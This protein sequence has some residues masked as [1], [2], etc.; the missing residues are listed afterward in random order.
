MMGDAESFALPP[1]IPR[2]ST[3]PDYGESSFQLKGYSMTTISKFTFGVLLAV[4]AGSFSIAA[5]ARQAPAAAAQSAM[6]DGEIKKVDKEGAKLTIKHGELKNLGMMPMTMVF[7]VQDPAML[8]KVTVGDKVRFV[9]DKV[10][11]ALTVKSLE[12]VK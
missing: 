1:Y 8:S 6:A 3:I 2:Y 12:I 9:A 7:R 10:N 5:Q 11:G 4:S